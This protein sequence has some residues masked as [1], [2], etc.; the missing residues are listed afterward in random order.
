M[1]GF[2]FFVVLLGIVFFSKNNA[3]RNVLVFQG[4][5]F[6]AV[7]VLYMLQIVTTMLAPLPLAVLGVVASV[8]AFL[9]S[10]RQRLSF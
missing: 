8:V 10:I 4:L 3:F 2:L 1:V 5:F 6:G 7:T 9:P